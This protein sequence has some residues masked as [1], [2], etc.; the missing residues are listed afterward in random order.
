MSAPVVAAYAPPLVEGRLVRRYQR[1]FADVELSGVGVV[2]AHCP[3]PGSMATCLVEG[4]RVWIQRKAG[5]G[6]LDWGWELAEVDGAM[7]SVNPTRSNGLVAAAL[8]AGAIPELHGY[9]KARRE[10]EAGESRLDFLLIKGAKPK[11]RCFVEVK[12]VTMAGDRP[13]LAQ[14]PDSVTERGVRHTDELRA[15]RKQGY[16]TALLFVV[17]RGGCTR[18]RPADAIDPAYGAALRA[19]AA[20]GVEILAYQ[21]VPSPRGLTWGAKVTVELGKAK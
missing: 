13:D 5:G 21:A 6:K 19:A 8:E 2:V 12:T 9:P 7:I 20:S 16:R 11:E 15:L 17:A 18:M 4:G 1:F 10:A 14:F 3:N